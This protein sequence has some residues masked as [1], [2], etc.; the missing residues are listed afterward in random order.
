MICDS[1]TCAPQPFWPLPPK[2]TRKTAGQCPRSKLQIRS[3]TQKKKKKQIRKPNYHS[4]A[5][6]TVSPP[7]ASPPLQ[8]NRPRY[9]HES[10]ISPFWSLSLSLIISKLW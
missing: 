6:S 4:F 5:H 3:K 9:A 2:K 8:S 10:L 1:D 7:L